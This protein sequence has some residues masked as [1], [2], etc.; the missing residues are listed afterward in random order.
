MKIF[1]SGMLRIAR[2]RC[3]LK[4]A[5]VAR[6]LHVTPQ[7]IGNMENGKVKT[8]TEDLAV[9]ADLYKVNLA[10]FFKERLH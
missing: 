5:D 1:D 9:L 7:T 8:S 2:R 6:V 10:D 3:H 4:Q